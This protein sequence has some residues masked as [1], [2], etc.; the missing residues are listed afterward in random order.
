VPI[1]SGEMRDTSLLT[2]RHSNKPHSLP[3]FT[4]A[5]RPLERVGAPRVTAERP[6]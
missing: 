2:S 5:W 6:E 4:G 1:T 3:N